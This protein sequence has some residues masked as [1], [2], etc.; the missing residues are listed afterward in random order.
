MVCSHI[1]PFC[2]LL[3]FNFPEMA[4]D[5]CFCKSLRSGLTRLIRDRWV[6]GPD[7]SGRKRFKRLRIPL[8]EMM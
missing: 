7:S 3:R 6:V 4:P 5:R 2:G 8:E 1:E